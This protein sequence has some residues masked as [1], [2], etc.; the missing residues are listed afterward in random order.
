MLS[1]PSSSSDKV[2]DIGSVAALD[3]ALGFVLPEVFLQDLSPSFVVI[4]IIGVF[5]ENTN[6]TGY[7]MTIN[8]KNF[9]VSLKLLKGM[10]LKSS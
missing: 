6:F 1:F 10:A 9:T 5:V 7:T 3:D 4:L 2:F 8:R